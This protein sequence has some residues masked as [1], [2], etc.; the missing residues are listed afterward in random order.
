MT[1]CIDTI[2][3]LLGAKFSIQNEV[4]GLQ[5]FFLYFRGGSLIRLWLAR[6]FGKIS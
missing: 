5:Q 4:V 1:S 6:I 2:F 3:T